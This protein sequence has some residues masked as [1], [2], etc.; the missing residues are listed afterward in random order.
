MDAANNPALTA[1]ESY[2]LWW[3]Q[4][5]FDE[6]CGEMAASWLNAASD[7]ATDFDAYIRGLEAKAPQSPEGAAQNAKPSDAKPAAINFPPLPDSMDAMG[8][9]YERLSAKAN[10]LCLPPIGSGQEPLCL[11]TDRPQ[12]DDIKEK[13]LLSGPDGQ[14]LD[15]ML[16]A[17]GLTRQDVLITA[18]IPWHSATPPSPD[19]QT[20]LTTLLRRQLSLLPSRH[21]LL[22]GDAGSMMLLGSTAIKMRGRLHDVNHD[23]GKMVGTAT[24]HPRGLLKKPM[25]KRQAWRDLQFLMKEMGF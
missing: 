15:Q 11:I 3:Q 8:E 17:I 6:P 21:V 2:F 24:Y 1:V 22:L 4:A 16:K 14:L 20:Y 12:V 23:V 18:A 5:G 10:R 13:A 9:F 25:A 7:D 19:A